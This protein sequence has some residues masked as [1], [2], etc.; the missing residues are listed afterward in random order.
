MI[1]RSVPSSREMSSPTALV[2]GC[3]TAGIM[4]GGRYNAN[5]L[6]ICLDSSRAFMRVMRAAMSRS[7]WLVRSEETLRKFLRLRRAI[8]DFVR[9]TMEEHDDDE[10]EEVDEPDETDEAPRTFRPHL[11]IASS[12][13][14]A[15]APSR[16]PARKDDDEEEEEESKVEV[17]MDE[18]EGAV[19]G[20]W[21][22]S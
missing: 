9:V 2:R 17:E 1:R 18:M 7:D 5:S 12:S 22:S 21:S 3:G 6:G 10:D 11:A 20:P 19:P 13:L 15:M 14:A 8:W 4:E 16:R